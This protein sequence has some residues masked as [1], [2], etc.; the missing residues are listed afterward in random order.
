MT[1]DRMILVALELEIISRGVEGGGEGI[2]R[3]PLFGD[4]FYTFVY[5]VLSLDIFHWNEKILALGV[6]VGQYSP[7]KKLSLVYQHVGI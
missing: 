5:K 6:C 1:Q 4:K 7:Q 2:V 3:P